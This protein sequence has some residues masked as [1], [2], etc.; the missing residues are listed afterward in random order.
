LTAYLWDHRREALAEAL[1]DLLSRG[2][3]WVARYKQGAAALHKAYP[4]LEVSARLAA[5]V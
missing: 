4:E 3:G 5:A 1:K 2:K